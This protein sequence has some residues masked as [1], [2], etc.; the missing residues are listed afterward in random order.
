VPEPRRG[1][2]A[3]A[4]TLLRAYAGRIRGIPHG[5]ILDGIEAVP[6]PGHTPGHTGY[7]VVGEDRSLMI[8]A[9]A[10]HVAELQMADPRVGLVFDLDPVVSAQTRQATLESAA[11]H[12]WIIAGGHLDGF[13]R[14]D[15]TEHGFRSVPLRP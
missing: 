9:D 4:E 12:G 10:L 3:V 15:R 6:L 11:R 1:G 7:H 8:L 14:V 13:H 2:F 5:L